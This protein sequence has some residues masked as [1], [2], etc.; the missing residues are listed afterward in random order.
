MPTAKVVPPT[1]RSVHE[2]RTLTSRGPWP[3]K[4][5]AE[6]SVL[7]ALPLGEALE[8]FFR[9]SPE[10]LGRVSQDIRGL[11]FYQVRGI[12]KNRV[13]GTEFHRLREEI[14]FV[15]RGRVHLVF[16]DLLGHQLERT[17]AEGDGVWLPPF[18]LHTYEALEDGTDLLVFC[19]TLFV[20]DD[21]ATHD[22][23]S[24]EEFRL[25]Q[26]QCDARHRFA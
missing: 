4:S 7:F 13:G 16:E 21:K 6:L 26:V 5:G 10:E 23:Y 18:I 1:Y 9:Y 14:I 24:N 20:P 17:L 8:V 11:R 22:T 3:T 15:L 19:N 2:V 12:P 25:L